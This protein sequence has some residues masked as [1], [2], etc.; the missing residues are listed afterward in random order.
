MNRMTDD[1]KSL[2]VGRSF[3]TYAMVATIAALLA[4]ALGYYL[5]RSL[6]SETVYGEVVIATGPD[7]G[8]YHALGKALQD[9]LERSGQFKSVTVK[10]TDGS[11]E[12]L[13]LLQEDP[14]VD[15]AFAQA[16]ASPNT[17]ARLLTTLYDEVLHVIVRRGGAGTMRS[18]YDLDGKRV[19]LGAEGSGTRELSRT[20]IEHLGIQPMEDRIANPREA[21]EALRKGELDG[22][23]I[24][25]AMPSEL[26]HQLAQEDAF[27]FISIGSL[28]GEGDEAAA[29]EL[30]I[31]GVERLVIPRATYRRLPDRPVSTIAVPAQLLARIQLDEELV[32]EV[33]RSIFSYR[34][35]NTGLEGRDLAVARQ[36]RENY[37]PATATVPYHPGAIA[38]YNRERPP[39]FVEYAEALSLGLT[40]LL[41]MY[42]VFIAFR[43]LLRRRMKNRV[44]AYLVQI[45]ALVVERE[46]LDKAGL[47]Q[48]WSELNALRRAAIAD[49]VGEKL[50]ADQAY[51]IMQRHFSEELALTRTHMD[52]P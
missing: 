45:E 19:S 22:L 41:G 5:Y 3:S 11:L 14:G 18:I 4:L 50:L 7:T 26:V 36:I 49:L 42:S 15:L 20:V 6:S 28:D 30:V 23:F 12:N 27:R 13:R 29:L 9:I 24:L 10:P 33:T 52:Q 37:D 25:A 51:Q 2:D 46:N 1:S 16:D 44:D 21:A 8:N 40:L 43:E 32:R 34:D 39:F 17:R 38:Y 35:G 31:P 47:A 48:L